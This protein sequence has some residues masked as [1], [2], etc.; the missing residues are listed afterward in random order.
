MSETK[1]VANNNHAEEEM[2]K[3]DV[4]FCTFRNIKTLVCTWNAGASKPQDLLNFRGDE[5]FLENVLTSVDSPDIIVFGFQEL[6]DLENKK[7]TAS[8]CYQEVCD[9]ILLTHSDVESIFKGKKSEKRLK[10]GDQEHMSRQYRLWQEHLSIS[11]DRYLPT[12]DRYQLLHA[13][14][15]V[16]LYTCIFIKSAERGK[17]RSIN[18]CSVK[19]GLGGL[20][21]NKVNHLCRNLI[22]RCAK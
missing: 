1:Y 8:K 22:L 15:L 6:V 19:T 17:V 2:Q 5:R 10:E 21:G 3:H 11:I 12:T 7:L 18:A 14:N 13:A 20:H 4:E 9:T 16:G